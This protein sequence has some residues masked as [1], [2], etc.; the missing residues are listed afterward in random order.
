LKSKRAATPLALAI[1]RDLLNDDRPSISNVAE[2]FMCGRAYT[3]KPQTGDDSNRFCSAHCREAFDAGMPRNVDLPTAADWIGRDLSRCIQ[4]AGPPIPR[5]DRCGGLCVEL[6]RKQ[7]KVFCHWRCRDDKPRDCVVC[8]RNLYNLGRKGPYCSDTCA[9]SSRHKKTRSLALTAKP[10][11]TVQE[12]PI[13]SALPH[14]GFA[15]HRRRRK[16]P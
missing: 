16:R 2:C 9:N 15:P 3:P 10:Q 4:I 8:G 1:Q 13:S 6:Y 5:C 14:P 7:G 11:N 12:V